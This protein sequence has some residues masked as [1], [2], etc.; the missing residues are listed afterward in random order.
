[1]FIGHFWTCLSGI[2]RK[3]LNYNEYLVKK[4]M[5]QSP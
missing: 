2:I 1:M 3:L 4:N 5:N